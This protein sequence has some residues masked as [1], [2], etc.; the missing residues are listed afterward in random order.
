MVFLAIRHLTARKRQSILTLLAIV[1]G[2][3]GYVVI[4]GFFAG[5]QD[6]L[7][8]QLINN[9][10]HLRVYAKEEFLTPSE[11]DREALPELGHAFWIA[12][13]SGRK[14]NARIL[15]PG[16][17]FRLLESDGRV[18]AFS[19]QLTAQVIVSRAQAS[20]PARVIGSN[21]A[22]QE[23]VSNI[24]DYM[25]VGKFSDIAQ[26]GKRLIVGD[27]LL[28]KLGARVSET[29]F[30]STGRATPVPFKIVASFHTGIKTL[31]EGTMF[32]NLSDAQ[33]LNGTPG[34]VNE[35]AVR[36]HDTQDAS[37]AARD[38]SAN[39]RD[40]VLS[41]D[42][43]NA[44]FLNVF[45]IQNA[46][47][48]VVTTIIL[49]IA[50]F[51]I[52]NILNVSVNQKRKDIAIL[53]SMGYEEGD[54]KNLF[55]SQ[56]LALGLVGGAVGLVIGFGVSNYLTTIKFGGGPLG[57]GGNLRVSFDVLIYVRAIVLSSAVASLASFLPARA[58]GKLQPIEI[59]RA[60]AE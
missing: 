51:G 21:P 15:D 31:D 18:K 9:D 52:Y 19:P 53:R 36:F 1:L 60:G 58:A 27:D 32:A 30:L 39:S 59:I 3:A 35:I 38:W 23:Y 24:R 13:P 50:G 10:A 7:L 47:K 37:R 55:L 46:L 25:L 42:Q 40:R 33:S 11:M 45:T 41:W 17:W 44:N 34:Q 28:N 29:V 12:P 6:F 43:I 54:I 26:G 2:S 20:S 5:F 4:S 49:L 57:G 22:Q 14:D 56:G 8:D 16:G 48:N